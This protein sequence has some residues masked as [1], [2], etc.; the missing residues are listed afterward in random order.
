MPCQVHDT[1]TDR[2]QI[3]TLPTFECR[4]P[5][6]LQGCLPTWSLGRCHLPG[7]AGFP[8]PAVSP[9]ME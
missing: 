1:G 7:W 5:A 9:V 6:L 3:T 4:A 2:L 8:L